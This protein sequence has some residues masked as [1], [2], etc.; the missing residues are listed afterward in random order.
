MFAKI[1][2]NGKNTHLIY[3]YFKW[4]SKELNIGNNIV[5]E[6]PWNFAKFLVDSEGNVLRFYNPKIEPKIL[7][8]DIKSF[9]NN[10]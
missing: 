2:V 3:K 7:E 8:P 5:K 6:V 4:N 10:I 9:L 1:D